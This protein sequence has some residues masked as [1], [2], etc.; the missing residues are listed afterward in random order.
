VVVIKDIGVVVHQDL[1]ENAEEM[2]HCL[3]NVLLR[4]QPNDMLQHLTQSEEEELL[5]WDAEKYRKSI[6]R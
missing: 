1:S 5:G 3:T 2:L 6:Q 4:L